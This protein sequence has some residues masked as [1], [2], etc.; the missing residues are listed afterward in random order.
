MACSLLIVSDAHAMP[1]ALEKVMEMAD[2]LCPISKRIFLG[3]AIGYG[4]DPVGVLELLKKFDV[5]IIGNHEALVLGLESRWKYNG[6]AARIIDQH[7]ELIGTEGNEFLATFRRNYEL[8]RMLFFHGMPASSTEYPFNIN[9]IDGLFKT[10]KEFDLFFG[11]H[12]H[13]PRLVACDK[14]TLE[15]TFEDVGE[16]GSRHLLDLEHNRYFINC[17]SVRLGRLG[18]VLPGA[19]LLTDTTN[20]QKVLEFVFLEEDWQ[21]QTQSMEKS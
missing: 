16:H 20:S 10:Y 9:D 5:R 19:C 8:S 3:D 12:L 1:L 2:S 18:Y 13:F 21:Q 11:G 4:D 17:P 6:R 7:A 14:V 15:I